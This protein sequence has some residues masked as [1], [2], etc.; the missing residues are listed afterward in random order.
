MIVVDLLGFLLQLQ[1]DIEAGVD[2]IEVDS[3]SNVFP[4]LYAKSALASCCYP[5]AEVKSIELVPPSESISFREKIKKSKVP[6]KAR[7][8][9]PDHS[10]GRA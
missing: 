9:P 4:K 1:D 5:Q 7:I 3:Y 8:V 2:G 6:I 10:G